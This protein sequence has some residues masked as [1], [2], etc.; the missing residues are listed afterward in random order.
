MAA[1]SRRRGLHGD[2][3]PFLKSCLANAGFPSVWAQTLASYVVTTPLF[4]SLQ[5]PANGPRTVSDDSVTR[6]V[7]EPIRRSKGGAGGINA[8]PSIAD[9][10]TSNA[11][12]GSVS[13]VKVRELARHKLISYAY[14]NCTESV[15]VAYDPSRI[16]YGLVAHLGVDRVSG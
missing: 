8:G 6:R 7:G 12:Y 14:S 3:L 11:S 13:T 9:S 5:D 4:R 10:T 16:T 1:K 2:S 15:E